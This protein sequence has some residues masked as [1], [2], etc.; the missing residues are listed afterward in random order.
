[1]IFYDVVY[2]TIPIPNVLRTKHGPVA[3]TQVLYDF[4]RLVMPEHVQENLESYMQ[5]IPP[6]LTRK[7][8]GSCVH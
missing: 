8:M 1:M 7:S 3:V 2:H 5:A 4:T 6:V